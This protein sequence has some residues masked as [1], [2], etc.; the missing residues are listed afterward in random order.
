M[1]EIL[2]QETPATGPD[3][4]SPFANPLPLLMIFLVIWWVL[5]IG[6]HRKKQKARQGRVDELKK[7]DRVLTR[8]GIVGTVVTSTDDQVTLKI[9]A[10][11]KVRVPFD[12]SFIEDV[13]IPPDES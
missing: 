10:D 3:A 8:G 7:G 2:A 5:V 12:K 4:G 1:L 6:P 11:G 9:D 13:I